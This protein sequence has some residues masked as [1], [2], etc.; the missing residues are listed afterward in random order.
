MSRSHL[1]TALE[2]VSRAFMFLRP[3]FC[4]TKLRVALSTMGDEPISVPGGMLFYVAV[5]AL[6]NQR[7]QLGAL[8]PAGKVVLLLKCFNNK[9]YEASV[10]VDSSA[11]AS[12]PAALAAVA[13]CVVERLLCS[14][15]P[16]AF[17]LAVF[18]GPASRTVLGTGFQ[19]S[20]VS[21]SGEPLLW[22]IPAAAVRDLDNKRRLQLSAPAAATASSNLLF[23]P[24][25]GGGAVPSTD[26]TSTDDTGKL[27]STFG[28]FLVGGLPPSLLYF[29]ASF[30]TAPVAPAA[31]ALWVAMQVYM[32]AVRPGSA[33]LKDATSFS[34]WLLPGSVDLGRLSAQCLRAVT[35]ICTTLF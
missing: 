24:T 13:P 30:P 32:P 29:M 12:L 27:L 8:T 21:A 33:A 1:H 22:N 18:S 15:S 34:N 28:A 31:G 23:P 4:H 10:G 2:D 3:D 19:F 5:V 35:A 25:G 7:G 9:V 14:S 20:A 6:L 26:V 16:T 17:L 11:V